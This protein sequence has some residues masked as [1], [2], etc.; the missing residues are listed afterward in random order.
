[1]ADWTEALLKELAQ[2]V[3]I[4]KRRVVIVDTDK[5]Y[6][7]ISS[8]KLENAGAMAKVEKHFTLGRKLTWKSVPPKDQPA[9]DFY[10]IK[11]WNNSCY[12]KGLVMAPP[13]YPA[14]YT[15]NYPRFLHGEVADLIINM[16]ETGRGLV[17][18]AFTTYAKKAI[19]DDDSPRD[20]RL[21]L[22]SVV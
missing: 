18:N 10:F 6:Y 19:K 20:H 2:E 3:V 22:Y 14:E 15:P 21:V 16:E 13:N 4:D 1:M 17:A 9:Q 5:S 12:K 7:T 8:G 11:V